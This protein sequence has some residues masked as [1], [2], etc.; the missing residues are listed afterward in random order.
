MKKDPELAWLNEVSSVP[1]Q[2]SLR[3]Q[4]A[5]FTAFFGGRGRYPRYKSRNGRQTAHYTRSAFRI[6]DGE[7]WLAKATA[8]LR[9]AWS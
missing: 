4:D 1:L 2:Q 5:A 9:I 7:L 3:H 6:R 8:P